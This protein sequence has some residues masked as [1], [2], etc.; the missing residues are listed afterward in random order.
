MSRN[1]VG[2]VDS[3]RVGVGGRRSGGICRN[4]SGRRMARM[5][6]QVGPSAAEELETFDAN[7]KKMSHW[8][9][10]KHREETKEK[11]SRANKGNIPWNKGK[12]HSEETRRKIAE[13]TRAAML[14]PEMREKMRRMNVG[15]K[16]DMETKR[17][18]RV[19][20]QESNTLKTLREGVKVKKGKL[21]IPMKVSK[22]TSGPV[23]FEY[24][25][26]LREKLNKFINAKL[27]DQKFVDE[28]NS[29]YEGATSAVKGGA[30]RQSR[31]LSEETRQKLS[32]KIRE[33]WAD[34]AYRERVMDG[35]RSKLEADGRRPLS[36]AHRKR[37]RESLLLFN[38]IREGALD[39]TDKKEKM[40]EMEAR[41]NKARE[42]KR[43][44]REAREKLKAERRLYREQ[45]RQ[46]E[47][48]RSQQDRSLVEILR[49]SGA[50]PDPEQ[51]GIVNISKFASA[52]DDLEDLPEIH[53][54]F[55]SEGDHVTTLANI[56]EAQAG[57][58]GRKKDD[59]LSLDGVEDSELGDD[60]DDYADDE[61]DDWDEELEEEEYM[62]LTLRAK[63][64]QPK[65][66]PVKKTLT[67]YVDGS[68]FEVDD[69]T[70]ERNSVT[71][72]NIA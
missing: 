15:R 39:N 34:P 4:H 43:A 28:L 27:G 53:L 63:S 69:E 59:D 1:E 65:E 42:R 11:I 45:N 32:L 8:L 22:Y 61:F 68:A 58:K 19:K 66:D 21:Q 36:S 13:R 70:E 72:S 16:H 60:D 44:Q 56:V 23:P 55:D 46:R 67:M 64:R 2:F 47:Q 9:G 29:I 54:D 7:S 14:R 5:V 31:K 48:M 20:V 33:M 17:K 25:Q 35:M 62:R 10:K 51:P 18:I 52:I 6:T 71:A 40:A 38:S 37:I 12:K 50:L 3:L 49:S 24:P 57:K 41:R 30:H 26:S